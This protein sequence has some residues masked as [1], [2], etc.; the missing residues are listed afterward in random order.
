[1]GAI[2]VQSSLPLRASRKRIDEKFSH[3]AGMDLE[4]QLSRHRVL[5]Q[6]SR[7]IS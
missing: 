1:M 6:L 5:P 3:T 2:R 4:V 7:K